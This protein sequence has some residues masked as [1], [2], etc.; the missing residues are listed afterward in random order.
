[1][2]KEF[3]KYTISNILIRASSFVIPL[4]LAYYYSEADYG[5]ISLGYTYLSFFATFFAFG[6]CESIQR[7]YP[8]IK[9]NGEE[10]LLGNIFSFDLIL[11]SCASLLFLVI[12]FFTN[13]F[14]EIPKDIFIMV[15]IIAYMKAL[16]NMG[17][18]ILQM[19][20]KSSKYV[21]ASLFSTFFDIV[22]I[23]IF[24]VIIRLPVRFRFIS[25]IVCNGVSTFL[26]FI[27]TKR[28]IKFDRKLFTPRFSQIIKFAFPCMLLPIMSWLLTSSDKIVMSK[29][30]TLSDVGIYSFCYSISQLPAILY[31]AFNTA[32][33][34]LFYTE[35]E[36]KEKIK[37][38]QTLFMGLY[39]VILLIFILFC[40][41][42]FNNITLFNKYMSG[43]RFIPIFLVTTFFVT[44]STLN[45]AHLIYAY[46][47]K[48]I[49]YQTTIT[50]VLNILFNYLFISRWGSLGAAL[51]SCT[52]MFL[53]MAL[54]FYLSIRFGYFAFKIK[55]MIVYTLL[56]LAGLLLATNLIILSAI[57]VIFGVFLFAFE[58]KNIYNI[59]KA[60]MK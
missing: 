17:L 15:L 51:A 21:I 28:S 50:G 22:L 3:S 44:I 60:E 41:I 26:I 58:R 8:E 13:L 20:Q 43:F 6:F 31:Q 56:F 59:I 36:N 25:L 30:G 9:E 39:L 10:G 1:M 7:F 19:E 12:C 42:F 27:Y 32:Y 2:I 29:I 33:T 57:I 18:S 52:T 16:Q 53:Q 38:I 24:V 4:I 37:T 14:A 5:L 49:F 47:T 46:K 23:V 48:I 11:V 40:N 55:Q 54:S 35:Y 45:N 34:P